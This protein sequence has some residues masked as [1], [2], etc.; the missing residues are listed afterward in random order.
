MKTILTRTAIAALAV[1]SLNQLR[2]FSFAAISLAP[3]FCTKT[4]KK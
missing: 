2:R 1:A 4:P 3:I